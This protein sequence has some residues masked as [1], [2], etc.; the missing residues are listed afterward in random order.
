[1]DDSDFDLFGPRS[2]A[3]PV[4]KPRA[5]A[6]TVPPLPYRYAG[7]VVQGGVVQLLLARDDRLVPVVQGE[8]LD[9]GYRVESVSAEE[10]VLVYVPLNARQSV[11]VTS[12]IG[13]DDPAPAAGIPRA[14]AP[15][16]NPPDAPRL[17]NSFDLARRP[18]SA[19]ARNGN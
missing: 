5:A 14:S 12:A 1:M 17:R 16:A 15:V 7:M 11:P 8:H 19:A 3:P 2:W 9:G 6:P 10:I 4:A 13:L 18:Q